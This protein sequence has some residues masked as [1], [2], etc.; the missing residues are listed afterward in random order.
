MLRHGAGHVVHKVYPFPLPPALL[1]DRYVNSRRPWPLL[2]TPFHPS[3]HRHSHTRLVSRLVLPYSPLF[4]P[5]SLQAFTRCK[6]PLHVTYH[7]DYLPSRLGLSERSC[8]FPIVSRSPGCTL[9]KS[10]SKARFNL[11]PFY[12]VDMAEANP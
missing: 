12:I 10:P 7:T 1:V 5:D 3:S 8:L 2:P 4:R 6:D 9:A 11:I